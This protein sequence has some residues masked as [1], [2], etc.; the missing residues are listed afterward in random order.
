MIRG[1]I[2]EFHRHP[3]FAALLEAVRAGRQVQSIAG[4][5][6]GARGLLVALLA[7]R[8]GFGIAVVAPDGERAELLHGDISYWLSHLDLK[9]AAV[10][11]P[12]FEVNYYRGL[13]PH[14]DISRQRAQALWLLR[15]G[16][17]RVVTL[18]V[19]ALMHRLP[20]PEELGALC[21]RIRV[22][23]EH[24]QG[25]LVL[26]LRRL[27]YVEE[28]PVTDVGEFSLRGYILDFFAPH[29]EYP[30]RLEFFGDT[31]ESI[32]SYD[33]E[34]QR[35]IATLD[36]AELIPMREICPS[37]EQ[38]RQWGERALEFWPFDEDAKQL[39]ERMIAAEAG[40]P[41]AGFEFLMPAVMP[42]PGSIF[43]Y[44]PN[45]LCLL[46]E[47]REIERRIEERLERMAR[48][49]AQACERMLPALEPERLDLSGHDL[50]REL[51]KRQRLALN[52]LI[53]AESQL[54]IETRPVRRYRGSIREIVA[55]AERACQSGE[56]SI[57]LL[58]TPGRAERLAEIMR[59]R[60]LPAHLVSEQDEN[61]RP[62]CAY[63]S[64][65][66]LSAGFK[67]PEI[68]LSL[69][70]PGDLF[71]ESEVKLARPARR[72]GAP[73]AGLFI[74]DF[75]DLSPGDYVVHVDHG[76][77]RFQGLR[78]IERNGEKQ[79]YM[80]ITYR[81]GDKLY[82][83]IDRLDLVQKWRGADEGA[84]QLDKL[85]GITWQRTKSRIKRSMRDIASELLKL[86]AS[87]TMVEGYTFSPDSEWQKEFEDGFEYQETP[88]QLAAI[89]ETKRDME[90]RR[91]MDRL[92]CGDVGYGKTE[93]A[94]RAAFKAVLDGKQV[95]LI[96]PTT[97]LALQH[98]NSFRARFE[99]FPVA[100]ELLSR[101]RAPS[102]QRRVLEELESGRVDIVIG[103]HRLLQRDVRFN[104]LGL[105]IIDEEQRFGVE[106][107]ERLK[108]LKTQ[109]DVLTL[110]AT[111]I[112]RTLHMALLGLRDMSVIE[113][114]PKD[115]LAIQTTVATFDHNVIR[116]A[117]ELE[118]A[119]KGQVYFVHNRIES[120]Y[121]IAALVK[122]L[123]PEARVA[124]AHGQMR[125]AELERVMVDFYSYRYDVL[126]ATT[127]IENGLDIPRANTI[128]IDRADTYGLAQLY[129]L[130]G[131]VGRSNRRAYAYL[132]IPPEDLLSDVARRRLAAIR[133]ASDLGAGF[134]I[135]AMD[136]EIRG[137]GNLLGPEQH[138][139]IN[140]VG[141]ELYCRLL[142][143]TIRELKGEKPEPEFRTTIDLK[144]DIRIPESYISNQNQR[145]RVYKRIAQAE[146]EEQLEK[147]REEVI[148]R[149]GKM[150][151]PVSNLFRYAR[152]KLEAR[153]LAVASIERSDGRLLIKFEEG[154]P[155]AKLVG[156]INRDKRLSLSSA[157]V[158]S[159]PLP[160][161]VDP[162][163]AAAGVL[164]Q[165]K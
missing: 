85:G 51:E 27:G 106:Q 75:R 71:E 53:S 125:E 115:R 69:F 26:L 65:G 47:P 8:L 144:L 13:S 37:P 146:S 11:L 5:T 108:K 12:G 123:C 95:A 3:S 56:R 101:L 141:F 163:A 154:A 156:L 30:T 83:P 40:Q 129:Q 34:S 113:T 60:R 49:Y 136:L 24:A 4:L 28:D 9:N 165:L 105:I 81:D 107:K 48:D 103:T 20:A 133:Q 130:R 139:N 87:R 104:D 64:T 152:L 137:T 149:Y 135:A 73:A 52:V 32:R 97:V 122:Q 29:T 155:V 78:T 164:R 126:V 42:L 21:R 98:Y 160:A 94:M 84:P 7:E 76:I 117:I 46:D 67:L 44:T 121:S 157:G 58:S 14:P 138:G 57:Y 112:P 2:S 116:S 66:N 131:R 89:A 128:I 143:N 132:L 159:A 162:V 88:D 63:L 100:I 150:P 39:R 110:S 50:E 36:S 80:L 15:E 124:V 93:V 61:I 23:E 72:R 1:I 145:L 86:Y 82:V 16:R 96:A 38:F 134:Q 70:A 31:V 17:A 79:E 35:S 111:P 33:P 102:E 161:G 109:V 77:G 68:G 148:D 140:A 91:P 153:R 118:L 120:I 119:R 10:Y 55:D 127:I 43:D 45:F 25:E 147:V 142:E 54:S 59:E 6:G 158:L 41:F 114:P 62:G 151:A 90:S 74:S 19:D 92:V 22:G 99:A 18:S